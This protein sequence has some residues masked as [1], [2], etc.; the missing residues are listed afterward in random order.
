MILVYLLYVRVVCVVE[1]HYMYFVIHSLP[2]TNSSPKRNMNSY[3]GVTLII[4]NKHPIL[5]L[6]SLNANLD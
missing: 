3:R 6:T 5:N 2:S 4:R 1:A